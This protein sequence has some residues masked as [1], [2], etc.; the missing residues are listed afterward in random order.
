MRSMHQP[1]YNDTIA[2]WHD[3]ARSFNN[4]EW[5]RATSYLNHLIGIIDP[6][7]DEM[8]LD[9]GSGTGLL[10]DALTCNG[11]RVFGV[12]ISS[13]MIAEASRGDGYPIYTVGDILHLPFQGSTFDKL[14]A[15]LTLHHMTSN[16]GRAMDECYRVLKDGG[17]IYISEGVPPSV[18]LRDWY[19]RMFK[20]KEDRITLMEDDIVDILTGANFHVISSSEYIM[21]S[22]SVRNWLENANLGRDIYSAIYKLHIALGPEGRTLYNMHITEDDILIDM[23]FVTVIGRK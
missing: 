8:I 15:R 13:D 17:R 19:T 16:V 12:D 6:G 5:A 20:L 7:I 10:T 9:L 22:C 1:Q 4:L 11:S 21:E 23:K 2:F 14:T 18:N 3:R